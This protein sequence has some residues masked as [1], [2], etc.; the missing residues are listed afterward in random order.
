M[1]NARSY[2]NKGPQDVIRAT[3]CQLGHKMPIGPQ[4]DNKYLCSVTTQ[5]MSSD[6]VTNV[7]PEDDNCICLRWT[8]HPFGDN[9]TLLHQC[10]KGTAIGLNSD[11]SS[12]VVKCIFEVFIWYCQ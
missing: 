8:L 11:S 7:E 9:H 2:D 5:Q 4:D 1:T 12:P 3:R 6:K 10:E